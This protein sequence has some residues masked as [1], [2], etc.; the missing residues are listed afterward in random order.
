MSIDERRL[1]DLFQEMLETPDIEAGDFDAS[2][3][4]DMLFLARELQ[5]LGQTAMPDADAALAR[6]RERVL[7]S[8]P[9]AAP[10]PQAATP[11]PQPERKQPFW[12]RWYGAWGPVM[13]WAPA[14]LMVFLSLVILMSV[15]FSASANAMPGNP[16]YAIKRTAESVALRLVSADKRDAIEAAIEGHRIQEVGYLRD[17]GIQT[18]VPSYEGEVHGCSGNVCEIGA[19]TVAL[20][21]EIAA[22]LR[23]GER[24]KVDIE[25]HP[26]SLVAISVAPGRTPTPA[27][28]LVA[29]EERPDVLAPGDTVASLATD[30]PAVVK[31]SPTRKPTRHPVR[32]AAEKKK[33]ATSPSKSTHSKPTTT[34]VTSVPKRRAHTATVRPVRTPAAAHTST[35]AATKAPPRAAAAPTATPAP[36]KPSK[37][38]P[39]ATPQRKPRVGVSTPPSRRSRVTPVVG[40]SRDRNAIQDKKVIRG[41][42]KRVYRA[43]GRIQW[44]V[45]GRYRVYLTRETKIVGKIAT[46]QWATVRAYR[47]HGR[48]KAS[49]IT[50]RKPSSKTA[51]PTPT[52]GSRRV[53]PVKPNPTPVGTRPPARRP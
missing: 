36:P 31:V 50:V 38:T 33:K 26:D 17:E 52:P 14:M 2:G 27:T 9:A 11:Q 32:T 47:Q 46:G 6:A 20:P 19:F 49:K 7:Q 40:Q 21:P 22:K 41:K 3:L 5:S 12:R 42:I 25:V 39:R 44:L 16:L 18:V 10:Q 4:G 13:A 34:S 51:A 43:G 24:V 28:V 37:S 8:L 29:S 15:T 1:Q 35:P 30:T 23:P 48:W 53:K 45:V